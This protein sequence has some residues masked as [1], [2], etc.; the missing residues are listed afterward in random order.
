MI[1][2]R[3]KDFSFN[4]LSLHKTYI[5]KKIQ[6]VKVNK[7]NVDKPTKK[8]ERE[9]G[10]WAVYYTSLQSFITKLSYSLA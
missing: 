5:C 1:K 6:K 3:G 4:G 2:E 8:S 10:Q 7:R 9:G